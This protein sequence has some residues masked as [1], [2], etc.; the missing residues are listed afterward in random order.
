MSLGNPTN[1]VI[2]VLLGLAAITFL[3]ASLTGGSKWRRLYDEERAEYASYAEGAD[4][5]LRTARQRIAELERDLGALQRQHADATARIATLKEEAV[6]RAPNV[7]P[8]TVVPSASAPE[9]AAVTEPVVEEPALAAPTIVAAETAAPVAHVPIAPESVADSVDAAPIAA[10]DAALSELPPAPIVGVTPLRA[11]EPIPELRASEAPVGIVHPALASSP[12]VEIPDLAPIAPE[13]PAV[14]E[15][16]F[17]EVPEAPRSPEPVEVIE[18]E[19]VETI[20]PAAP[21]EQAIAAEAT[22]DEV[23]ATTAAPLAAA[24]E[25]LASAEPVA[26]VAEANATAAE[27]SPAEPAKSWFGS[28]RR[29]NLTRL[30]GV[31]PLISN[32]LFALGVTTYDDI[33]QL[34]H[35]DEMALEQRLGVPAGF[36]TREQ[37][38]TQASLLRFGKEDEFNERFGKLE[39]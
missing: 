36:I 32:R 15:A 30:S 24:A 18:A 28:G 23:P 5:E 21:V 4:T 10:V 20:A 33:V 37:W 6:A 22:V 34:S 39:A 26:A 19:A 38:R 29:D 7:V 25:S 31:D 2:I 17:A 11:P 13:A 16:V 27:T 14:E 12:P 8:L 1:I 35:E 3:I 9:P